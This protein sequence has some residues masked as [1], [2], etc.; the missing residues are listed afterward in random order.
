MFQRL[1][2]KLNKKKQQTQVTENTI[3]DILREDLNEYI[4]RGDLKEYLERIERDKRKKELWD[5]LPAYKKMK[6]LR[7]AIEKKG[8]SHD[9]KSR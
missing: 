3:R 8:A 1:R 5:S 7:Y 4:K 2:L 9:A 6:L